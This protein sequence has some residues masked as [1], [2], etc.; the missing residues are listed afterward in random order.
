MSLFSKSVS[1]LNFSDLQELLDGEACENIRLE[2]KQVAPIK[3]E[4]MKKIS[5]FANTYGGWLIVGAA[6]SERGKLGSLPGVGEI[7]NYKQTLIQWC[8]DSIGPPIDIQV[9]EAIPVEDIADRFIYVIFVP[10]SYLA[11]HFLNERKG[12][13][14]RTD[15]YSQHF[16]PKMATL[17][18]ILRL[19]GR[20]KAV[21]DRRRFLIQRAKTRFNT[22]TE[23]SYDRLG[24]NPHGLGANLSLVI[25]PRYPDRQIFEALNLLETV[26][27][28][29]IPWRKVG[30][31][32]ITQ[33]CI[34]QHESVL[35]LRPGSNFSLLEVNVWGLLA[36]STE[37]EIEIGASDDST[38]PYA[39]HLNH[40]LGQLLVFTEHAK[41]ILESCEYRGNLLVNLDLNNIRGAPWMHFPDGIPLEGPNSVLDDVATI[42]FDIEADRLIES[43]DDVVKDFLREIFFAMNWPEVANT[44]RQLD[45]LI[46]AGYNFNMWSRVS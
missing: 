33:G 4:M 26:R 46:D 22:F 38:P 3:S 8:F 10:E 11:P 2:F 25:S 35:V 7:S 42:D 34:T 12:I 45:R 14:I 29:K 16:E 41:R 15:E 1:S 44:D 19:S 32:R 24:K 27:S 5:S 43:S 36:Y 13:Y 23:T 17:D 40:F 30:F 21:L 28:L 18:E 37:L 20:R 39:I 31:P 9:S 6:E